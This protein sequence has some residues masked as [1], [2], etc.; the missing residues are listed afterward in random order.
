[1]DMIYTL[2]FSPR[3]RAFASRL[4]VSAA[5]RASHARRTDS[6]AALRP[7][8][9][10]WS[11]SPHAH[12]SQY[13]RKTCRAAGRMRRA[14]R[15]LEHVQVDCAVVVLRGHDCKPAVDEPPPRALM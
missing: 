8:T 15:A 3:A 9:S 6:L 5:Q 1:M 14:E 12:A 10:T 4:H 7:P 2:L 13:L 11:A